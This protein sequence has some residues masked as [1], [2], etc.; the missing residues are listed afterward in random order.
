[1]GN[2][3]YFLIAHLFVLLSTI[4]LY[5]YQNF[6]STHLLINIELFTG[7]CYYKYCE[8]LCA[9]ENVANAS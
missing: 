2:F 3:S 6:L 4:P 7:L 8:H 9:R 1:M 5:I